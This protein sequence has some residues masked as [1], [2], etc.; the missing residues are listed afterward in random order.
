MTSLGPCPRTQVLHVQKLAVVVLH[1]GQKQQRD[2][3]AA[4]VEYPLQVVDVQRPV[5]SAWG[6]LEQCL[7]G[8][9]TSQANL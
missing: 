4:V 3:F 6:P 1:T 5:G 7:R 2:L 9:E 8:V